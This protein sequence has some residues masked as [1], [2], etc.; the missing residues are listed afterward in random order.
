M[1]AKPG[2]VEEGVG[3]TVTCNHKSYLFQ[4]DLGIVNKHQ[5]A[6][7]NLR[8]YVSKHMNPNPDVARGEASALPKCLASF[9]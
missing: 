3:I 1:A 4:C 2:N 5:K 7:T 6:T 8:A 9:T